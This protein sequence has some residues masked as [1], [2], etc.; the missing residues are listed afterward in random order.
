M[1][2]IKKR[3]IIAMTGASGSILALDLLHKFRLQPE[4]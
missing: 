4:W 1:K 3:L 2:N